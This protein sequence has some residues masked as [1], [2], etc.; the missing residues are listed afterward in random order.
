MDDN[1]PTPT[2]PA[3]DAAEGIANQAHG[4]VRYGG[5]GPEAHEFIDERLAIIREALADRITPAETTEEW[6]IEYPG[7]GARYGTEQ[8]VR[9]AHAQTGFPIARRTAA[10]PWE[11]A[12]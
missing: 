3:L 7:L 12:S 8:E 6:A 2:D 11:V 1:T 9:D 5:F 10:G 4:Y